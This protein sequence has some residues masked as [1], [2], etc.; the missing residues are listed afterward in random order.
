[1]RITADK[2]IRLAETTSTNDFLLENY[3]KYDEG[4]MVIADYQSSGKGLEDNQWESKKGKNLT[5]SLLIKPGDLNAADQ[6]NLNM[7]TSLAIRMLISEYTRTPVQVKWPNDIYV[8]DK[9]IAGILI[10]NF[11]YG[12]Q[13]HLSIAGMGININQEKFYSEAPNPVSLK[14]ITG[15][16][17]NLKEMMDKLIKHL[18]HYFRILYNKDFNTLNQEYYQH[19][20]Q[21]NEWHNYMIHDQIVRASIQGIDEFGRLTLT[22][23]QG[24][25]YVCDLKEI[26]FLLDS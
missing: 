23:M 16:E 14:Q 20:Y 9:K 25:L 2:I 26:E 11:L 1:M 10:K 15:K 3:K 13:I 17:Y 22:D 6:F 21:L 7:A 8:D 19:M 18:E 5:L 24:R 4:T 12:Q